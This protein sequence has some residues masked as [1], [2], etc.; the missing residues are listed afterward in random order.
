MRKSL[1]EAYD[2]IALPSERITA[3][4][5]DRDIA[6]LYHAMYPQEK[7]I[8]HQHACLKSGDPALQWSVVEFHHKM[9][10]LVGPQSDYYARVMT[11]AT[12]RLSPERGTAAVTPDLLRHEDLDE[13]KTALAARA[14]RRSR[15]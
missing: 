7:E 11:A 8:N 12:T 3:E 14:R 1:A 13:A 4:L 5:S 10:E 2:C 9:M 15:R 6:K